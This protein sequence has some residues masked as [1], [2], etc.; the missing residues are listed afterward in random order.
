MVCIW[1]LFSGIFYTFSIST[2]SKI[3][4]DYS[5]QKFL[6][7]NRC[8]IVTETFGKA[9]LPAR[10]KD[11]TIKYLRTTFFKNKDRIS[12]NGLKVLFSELP[13]N[14]KFSIANEIY[15]G[16]IKEINIFNLCSKNFISNII[17]LLQPLNI[18][19]NCI[20]YECHEVPYKMFFISKGSVKFLTSDD[21]SFSNLNHSHYLFNCFTLILFL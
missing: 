20:V 17:P 1:L 15:D 4:L 3:F 6:L 12:S 13:N 2:L 16:A 19:K 10:I 21:I 7:N 5:S 14:L 8:L 9:Q 18:A 11:E